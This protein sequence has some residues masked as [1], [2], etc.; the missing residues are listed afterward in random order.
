MCFPSMA[1]F[2]VL[3]LI[4]QQ[5]NDNPDLPFY[6]TLSFFCCFRNTNSLLGKHST[7]GCFC[8]I[9]SKRSRIFG[10]FFKKKALHNCIICAVRLWLEQLDSNQRNDGVKV[11]CLTTWLYPNDI[12]SIIAKIRQ[13][14]NRETQFYNLDTKETALKAP[15]NFEK[16]EVD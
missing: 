10:I 2:M 13:S 9:K 1:F 7:A 5:K 3:I 8:L 12:Y 14:V 11:R 16:L 6:F 4:L 15:E